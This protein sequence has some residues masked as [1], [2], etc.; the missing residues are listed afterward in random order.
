MWDYFDIY[1]GAYV[2]LGILLWGF[3]LFMPIF[4]WGQM[5]VGEWGV[6]L[7]PTLP[8][9][10]LGKY[11]PCIKAKTDA[12]YP[13]LKKIYFLLL[14]YVFGPRILYVFLVIILEGK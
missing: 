10:T 1:R 3:C 11:I 2:H 13:V 7:C 8:N 4:I 14:R 6:G 5:S 9:S 12:L